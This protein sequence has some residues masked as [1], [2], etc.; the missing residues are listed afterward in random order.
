MGPNWMCGQEVA[1]RVMACTFAAHVLAASPATTDERWAK[2]VVLLAASAERIAGNI[3]FAIAQRGNHAVSEAAGLWTVGVLF[4]ELRSATTWR[5]I[6]RAVLETEARGNNWADGSYIQHSINYQ[7]MMLHCY[8]WSLGLARLNGERFADDLYGR[9]QSSCRFLYELQ[10]PTTSRL[11]NYGPNDGAQ[12]LPLDGCEYSDYRPVIGALHHLLNSERLYEN[13]PW[14]EGL[15]WLFGPGS[16]VSPLHPAERRPQDFPIGGYFVL[17]GAES[18]GMVRCHTYRCRPSQA[19]M[20]H[21]DLWWRGVNILRDSGTYTYYDPQNAWNRYFVSTAAHNTI[22]IGGA[23]QMVKGPRFRW[24][25]L[26]KYRYLGRRVLGTA[27]IWEGERTARTG[28][29]SPPPAG[30]SGS[31]RGLTPSSR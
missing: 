26:L 24:N 3:G 14:S 8:L 21:L 16:L 28:C 31:T 27:E 18:W 9:L 11:P 29:W 25:S 7:R 17:R 19:D 5:R 10:D 2:L 13:G 12:I 1:L 30:W 20:L 6:G 15:V 4:P 22:A 23:D